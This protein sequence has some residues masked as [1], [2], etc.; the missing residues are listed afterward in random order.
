MTRITK[1]AQTVRTL[2]KKDF[3]D[4]FKKV[5]VLIT[6]TSPFTAFTVGEKSS[7]PL[8]L[9]LAD[10]MVSP[11]AIAG[12]PALSVPAGVDSAGLPIGTQIIGSRAHED[13]IFAIGN[14]L[15]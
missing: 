11:A 15:Q 9:Y 1:K 10:V 4:V 8:A 6:P 14:A 5:D 12:V 7:D 2:I 13:L 3:D